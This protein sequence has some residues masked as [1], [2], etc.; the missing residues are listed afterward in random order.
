M[1]DENI[2]FPRE[3]TIA[4]VS[5]ERAVA[6]TIVE[7]SDS[8]AC[9]V[10]GLSCDGQRTAVADSVVVASSR[11]SSQPDSCSCKAMMVRWVNDVPTKTV[12]ECMMSG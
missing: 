9:A 5:D 10:V 7:V 6:S 12:S 3:I 4:G 1:L 11:R 2:G 8:S